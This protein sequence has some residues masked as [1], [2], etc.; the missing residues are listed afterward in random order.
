MKQRIKQTQGLLQATGIAEEP[1]GLYY[2]DIL[3]DPAYGPQT[4][5]KLS[6]EVE[7]RGEIDIFN[8][9]FSTKE[10]DSGLGLALTRK[11]LH[12]MDGTVYLYSRPGSNTLISMA[13]R[14]VFGKAEMSEG[15]NSH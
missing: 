8:P 15:M 11:L 12:E 7:A 14:P 10:Q 2:S 3:L 4:G 9:L 13:L 1:C 6:R 5:P